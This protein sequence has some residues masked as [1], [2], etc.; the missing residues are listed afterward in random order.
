MSSNGILSFDYQ[1]P[2]FNSQIFP[3]S[4]SITPIIAPFW[5]DIN[6]INGGS[7]YYRQTSEAGLLQKA[8]NLTRSGFP[9]TAQ[10]F[11]PVH[12]FIA[13]WDRV[14]PFG[15]FSDEEVYKL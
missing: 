14:A 13:T 1:F 7:I 2:D 12:L 5:T 8:E 3:L 10:D 11:S 6:I 15:G 9:Q 4:D